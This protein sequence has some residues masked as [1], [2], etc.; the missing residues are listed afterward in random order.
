MGYSEEQLQ[1]LAVT[2]DDSSAEVVI[3][4]TPIDLAALI[5]VDKPVIRVTYEFAEAGGSPTLQSVVDAFLR[6]WFSK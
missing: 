4:G 2:I 6:R 5:R 3:A 1:S